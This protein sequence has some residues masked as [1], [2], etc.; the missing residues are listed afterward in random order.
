MEVVEKINLSL[1]SKLMMLEMEYK[2]R[3]DLGMT[4]NHLVQ[5]FLSK[6]QSV[7]IL[8]MLSTSMLLKDNVSS[9]VKITS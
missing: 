1:M 9:L 7:G 5:Y 6:M 4:S 3:S 2:L 8:R